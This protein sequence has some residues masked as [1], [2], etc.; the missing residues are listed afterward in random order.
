MPNLA[1]LLRTSREMGITFVPY[2]RF[3]VQTRLTPEECAARFRAVMQPQK[4]PTLFSARTSPEAHLLFKGT[5]T[6]TGFLAVPVD[7]KG[8]G[9]LRKY[10][11]VQPFWVSGKFQPAFGG[12]D[13]V[14]QVFPSVL[15]LLGGCVLLWYTGD[16]AAFYFKKMLFSS[17]GYDRGMAVI[18]VPFLVSITLIIAVAMTLSVSFQAY[19]IKNALRQVLSE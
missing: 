3:R 18:A 6:R 14:V 9:G 1:T 19:K 13:L 16:S 8:E 17:D 15:G 2:A 4:L 7:N 10:R 12:T 5:V 11:G